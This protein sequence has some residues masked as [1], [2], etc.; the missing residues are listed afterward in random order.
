MTLQQIATAVDGLV[1]GDPDLLVRGCAY[2]DTRRAVG[3]GLFVAVAGTRVDGHDHAGGAHAV[4][5]SRPTS[6]PTVVVADTTVALGRLARAVVAHRAPRVVAVT[7]SHGKTAVKEFLAAILPGATATHGNQNNELGVA[8]TALR[9]PAHGGDLV[10]EMGARAV[11]H[12]TYLAGITPPD[13]SAVTALGHSHLERF[14]GPHLLEAAKR[15]LPQATSGVCVLN[16]DDPRVLAM[17]A[18]TWARVVTFG[19]RGDVGWSA[20]TLDEVGRAGF[21]LHPGGA[22]VAVRLGVVGAHQVANAACAAALALAAGT[23]VEAVV[24]G[25]E[26]TGG[27]E[28]RL[29]PRRRDDGGL[30]LDDCYNAAPASMA[31]ALRAL[32]AVAGPGHRV[33]VLGAM[34]ELGEVSGRGH[35]MVGALARRLGVDVVGVGPGAQDLAAAG[36]WVANPE[37]ALGVLRERLSPDD[38]VLVKAS[39]TEALERVADA[40]LPR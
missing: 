5:G 27:G 9:L 30:L 29:R 14:G 2:L 39:R 38:V 3:D 4:L 8:L 16:A 12:L 32:A 24:A 10:V 31:A 25:L 37:A 11:G 7:G 19:T 34:R 33:A 35:R 26:R 18:H 15:E 20:V 6:A 36:T 28:R 13:L 17:A 40:L 21:L 23:P 1:V 22:P